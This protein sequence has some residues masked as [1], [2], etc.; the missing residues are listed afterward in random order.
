MRQ[1][2]IIVPFVIVVWLTH[3][4]LSTIGSGQYIESREIQGT[5]YY[6]YV[7]DEYEEEEDYYG[8]GMRNIVTMYNVQ[9]YTSFIAIMFKHDTHYVK[10]LADA[11]EELENELITKSELVKRVKT[12]K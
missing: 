11:V 8:L 9:S 10:C 4:I 5:T 1:V 3:A 2:L 7:V 12:C 6:F